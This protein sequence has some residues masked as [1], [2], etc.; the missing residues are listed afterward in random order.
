MI[1]WTTQSFRLRNSEEQPWIQQDHNY[2][3]IGIQIF[4]V[5]HTNSIICDRKTTIAVLYCRGNEEISEDNL[6]LA[7]LTILGQIIGPCVRALVLGLVLLETGG[8][9]GGMTSPVGV[10]WALGTPPK[11]WRDLASHFLSFLLSQSNCHPTKAARTETP[12]LKPPKLRATTSFSLTGQPLTPFLL[13]DQQLSGT[14]T[15]HVCLS[16]FLLIVVMPG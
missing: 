15:G 4:I 7:P 12:S 5:S 16:Q 13:S 11:G 2:I 10:L 14:L 3:L 1:Q 6:C 9:S 8:T